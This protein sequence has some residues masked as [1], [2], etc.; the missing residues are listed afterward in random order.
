[1]ITFNLKKIVLSLVLG[2]TIFLGGTSTA[3]AADTYWAYQYRVSQGYIAGAV[4]LGIGVKNFFDPTQMQGLK[5]DFAAVMPPSQLSQEFPTEAECLAAARNLDQSY[6]T[7]TSFCSSYTKAEI[8][9]TR[10]ADVKAIGDYTSI[11]PG[12]FTEASALD[13]YNLHCGISLP[14][15]TV[16][17]SMMDCIPSV[18]YYALY[19]PASF[20]LIGSGYIFDTMLGLSIKGNLVAPP[21]IDSTW[22]IVRDFSN[23]IFIFILLY[24]GIMTMFGAADW[25]KVVLQVVFIA[26]LI[27]FSLFFTKVVIDAGNILAVG[28]LSSINP[29][30]SVSEGLARALQPQYFL[31]VAGGLEDTLNATIVFLVATVVSG[32]AAYIFFK[33]GLLFAGRLIAFWFLMIVSPFAF[34]STALPKGNKFHDWLD[35]LLGQAFVA[36]VFLFFVYII[37]MV[38]SSGNGILGGFTLTGSWFKALIGPVIVA[39]L[40]VLALQKALEFAEEMAGSFGKL[41]SGMVSAAMGLAI[42][43]GAGIVRSQIGGEAAYR[44][45]KGLR[46][47]EELE[48][49]KPEEREKYEKARARLQSITRMSFDPRNIGGKDS[50]FGEKVGG[51]IAKGISAFG[52]GK[53]GGAGGVEKGA[54]TQQEK[55]LA[56]AKGAEMSIFEESAMRARAAKEI[57]TQKKAAEATAK[58]A[59]AAKGLTAATKASVAAAEKAHAESA[60]AKEVERTASEYKKAVDDVMGHRGSPEARDAAKAA[61]EQAQ[62]AHAVAPT[63]ITLAKTLAKLKEAENAE[64]AAVE[65][66]AVAAAKAKNQEEAAKEITKEIKT[67]NTGMRSVYAERAEKADR[68]VSAA[69]IRKGEGPKNTMSEFKDLM[70]K[71]D[72]EDKEHGGGHEE[73]KPKAA[74]SHSAPETSHAAP[75][76]DHSAPAA[77]HGADHH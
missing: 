39:T 36:P 75:A 45:K 56:E 61:Y 1:M 65:A 42:S 70:K 13:Q 68:Y 72:K 40:L 29:G 49:M 55:D 76:A 50:I 43:G 67:I 28:V 44:L 33:I 9:A 19:K 6:Y 2:I 63:S 27:N 71:L 47:P 16:K 15:S 32:Y 3:S 23:M 58:L 54:K 21:F 53:G 37:M 11:L 14:G 30:G 5:G 12:D 73:A 20:A 4:N 7:L 59:E 8:A 48:K 25:R 18:V 57:E 60:T 66:V 51:G 34:I 41:G 38:I 64:R 17:Y 10:A 31:A 22:I 46:T 69:K 52:L 77:S 26:L 35:T 62:S 74:A 24:T